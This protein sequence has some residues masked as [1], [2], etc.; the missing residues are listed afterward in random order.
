MKN[1]I[2]QRTVLLAEYIISNNATVRAAAC[3]FGIS[4][5]TVHKDISERLREISPSLSKKAC[6]VLRKNKEERHIRGGLATKQKYA[7]KM[8]V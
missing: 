1:Y 4:K 5:S 7:S 8:M 6:A 2:E 3:H